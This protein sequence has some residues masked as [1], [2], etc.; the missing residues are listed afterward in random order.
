MNRIPVAA[1]IILT[2]TLVFTAG[3]TTKKTVARET[4]PLINKTNELDDLTAKTTRDIKDLDARTTQGLNDVNSKSAA[5]DQKAQAAQQA[6]D[7]AN[8]AANKAM[9]GVDALTNQVANLDNYH[10]VAETTVHF[11]FD[12]ADLSKKAKDALDKLAAEIAN[13]KGY[14]IALDGNTDSTGPADY[15]YQLSQRRARSVIQYLATE[16]Q[17]P[18]HKIYLIG[19]GKDKPVAQNNTR[20]GRAENRRVDVKLMTNVAGAQ[21]EN[22]NQA[23][24]TAQQ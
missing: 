8:Q 16:H 3:C 6:A 5:A 17:V 22:P 13:T 2:G 10:S 1:A 14:I 4:A 19:L 15:N 18:A 23:P 21:A 9:T 12:N 20:E 7:Q 24:T 11:G